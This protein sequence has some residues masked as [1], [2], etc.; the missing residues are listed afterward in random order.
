M[1]NPLSKLDM[2]Y[3]INT[4]KEAGKRIMEVYASE[5]FDVQ[6]KGDDSP[7]TKADTISHNY[8]KERL[9]EKYPEIHLL[10][11]EG[12]E[13]PYEE[14]KDWTTFWLIDPLDG[15]KEFIKRNGEFTVNIGL[16]H[17]GQPI[18]GIIYAPALEILYYGNKEI[19]SFKQEGEGEHQKLPLKYNHG[20]DIVAVQSRSHSSDEENEVLKK[21]GVTKSI[22]IGSSLKFCMV[23]EGKAH[24]YYR[25]GPTW[26]WDTAAGHGISAAEGKLISGLAYNKTTLLNSSFQV[27]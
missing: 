18:L 22:S 7:L 27:R 24:I 17:E 16:I 6:L 19:G 4:A 13:I 2:E 11:E 25:H 20:N 26:E 1:N 12:K 9:S 21:H 14:R 10:S 8:I 3:L 23:A 5:D 15:T